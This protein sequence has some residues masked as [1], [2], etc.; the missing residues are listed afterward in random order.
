[1]SLQQQKNASF[2][3]ALV[4]RWGRH[5]RIQFL[6]FRDRRRQ[7]RLWLGSVAVASLLGSGRG[8]GKNS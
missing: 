4:A 1:M 5:R 3:G 8:M 6:T 2:G 7:Q